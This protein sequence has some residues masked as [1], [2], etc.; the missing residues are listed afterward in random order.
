MK[1]ALAV[2]ALLAC[3]ALPSF[4]AVTDTMFNI[5][6]QNSSSVMTIDPESKGDVFKFELG[7]QAD[8]NMIFDD[9]PGFDVALTAE[10]N[11]SSL[12]LGVYYAHKVDVKDNFDIVEFPKHGD[13]V[14][15]FAIE[16]PLPS[17]ALGLR[18]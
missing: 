16:I 14:T 1:K 17:V 8:F 7:L 15:H 6:L 9:G 5:G 10:Q 3:I 11:F 4:A 12:E 2:L 13:P 18:F